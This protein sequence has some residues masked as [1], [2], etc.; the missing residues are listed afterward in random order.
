MVA[1]FND[2][3]IMLNYFCNKFKKNIKFAKKKTCKLQNLIFAL[4]PH[5][6]LLYI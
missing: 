6:F 1:N 4:N 3:A 5:V 2:P